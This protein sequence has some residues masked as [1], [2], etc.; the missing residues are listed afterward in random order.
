[1]KKIRINLTVAEYNALQ[2]ITSK[3]H[4]DDW[5]WLSIDDEGFDCVRNLDTGRK[6]TLRTGMKWLWEGIDWMQEADWDILG[7]T[8]EEVV[9]LHDILRKLEVSK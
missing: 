8:Q 5:F 6:I 9:L 4:Q 1:M 3:T 7:I 2:H